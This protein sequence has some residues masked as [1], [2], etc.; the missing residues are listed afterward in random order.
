MINYGNMERA[1]K[2]NIGEL[3]KSQVS[4]T[5][6]VDIVELMLPFSILFGVICISPILLLLEHIHKRKENKEK[7]FKPFMKGVL[8]K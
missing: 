3:Q 6:K 1:L 2:I 7:L 4:D 5:K 8:S